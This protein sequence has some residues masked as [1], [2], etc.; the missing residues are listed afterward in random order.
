[1]LE[2][3]LEHAEKMAATGYKSNDAKATFQL[4]H[5]E[6]MS[7][8]N[9][10][11]YFKSERTKFVNWTFCDPDYTFSS[12]KI[13]CDRAETFMTNLINQSNNISKES[14]RIRNQYFMGL[15]QQLKK[16]KLLY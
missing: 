6:L 9:N 10:V 8:T 14:L 11:V 5:S 15:R 1:L 7:A 13:L 4:Y 12:D 3:V 16:E 2:N